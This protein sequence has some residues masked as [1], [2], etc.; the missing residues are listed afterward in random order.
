MISL[1]SAVY[2]VNIKTDCIGD[3]SNKTDC[4]GQIEKNKTQNNSNG[5]GS[6][7]S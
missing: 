2:D 5:I 6:E 7:L 3:A 1:V 4:I